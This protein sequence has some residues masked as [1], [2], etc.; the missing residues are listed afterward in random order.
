M[1]LGHGFS[2]LTTTVLS[3]ISEYRITEPMLVPPIVIR[4]VRDPIVKSKEYD[5]SCL[6]AFSCGA[7]PLSEEILYLLQEKFP[8]IGFKQG[9]G[10]TESCSCITMH[11]PSFS[12]FRCECISL[13][14]SS[15]VI[16]L[17]NL[18]C[19][20]ISNLTDNLYRCP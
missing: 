2:R 11:P 17:T 13:E 1:T 4:L 7:A 9:Y 8:G 15:P 10:M 18:R 3:V 19:L 12:T 14:R 20:T 6:K 5:L 16:L